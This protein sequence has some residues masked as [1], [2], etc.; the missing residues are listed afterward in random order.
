MK[1]AIRNVYT[2]QAW[3]LEGSPV[4]VEAQIAFSFP[5]LVAHNPRWHGNPRAMLRYLGA[6]QAFIV[7]IY[8]RAL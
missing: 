2:R 7:E 5:W 6:Q 3:T 4:E 1:V 8:E